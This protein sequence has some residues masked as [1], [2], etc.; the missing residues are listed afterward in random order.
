MIAVTLGQLVEDVHGTFAGSG[1]SLVT[2][3]STDTRTIEPGSVFAA[4]KGERVDGAA[5]AGDALQAGA[6]A[7]LTS[8]PATAAQ[9]GVQDDQIIVVPDVQRAIGDL[10][11]ANL[12]R[13]RAT[14]RP[15]FKI[16]AITGSVG[17][18][19]TKDLLASILASRGPIIAPVG[20][21]NNELGLPLTALKADESTATLVLE[22]GAD[23]I[24]NIEYLTSIAPP[25]ICAVLIVARA[26]LGEFGGIENVARAKSELVVGTRAGGPVVLNADDPRVFGMRDLA[27]GPVTT[28]SPSGNGDV[29]AQS[30]R[31]DPAGRASF[32]L[33]TSVGRES[34]NL[35]LVGAHHVSNALA[36]ATVALVMGI[37]LHTIARVL[38]TT[39]PAS[40]H[41][42]DVRTIS[43]IT[44]I[45]DSYNGNPDSMR[46]G[47][48][49]LG[50]LG[51]ER[52]RIAVIGA[53]LELGDATND[54]HAALAKV[55]KDAG[56]AIMICVGDSH[57]LDVA[58]TAEGIDVFS[59]ASPEEAI[60]VLRHL[61][62]AGDA[63]L[64]KGS[65]GSG[66]WRVADAMFG[67][68]S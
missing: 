18:T 46:A 58:A 29:S 21:F 9:S 23:H 57:T 65:N 37:D 30:V 48:A 54:E 53:M 52:R 51:R 39:G 43:G 31:V 28:F 2:D 32:T 26:H 61:L 33:V 13:T 62:Q 63:V 60:G 17:K 1:E 55:A 7:V 15:D 20:S 50:H 66:L 44:F 24:G 19:T 59:A 22:M 35:R 25:D 41:R 45:D 8:D 64:L 6:V 12:E 40:P 10:A 67:K 38:S 47:F 36:A 49:A 5:L 34:V 27:K 68:E 56:V 16:V 42:M 4:I 11:R 14:G 3:L